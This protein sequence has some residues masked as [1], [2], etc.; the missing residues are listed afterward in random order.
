MG[1][2]DRLQSALAHRGLAVV[3]VSED[4]GGLELVAPFYR[5]HG[6]EAL[7][8]YLDPEGRL[9]RAFGIAGLPTTFLIDSEGRL[10]GELRGAAEWDGPAA[11][12]LVG[13]YLE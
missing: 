1:S 2:L 13:H 11:R 10:V 8:I 4:R 6:L 3:A 12:A 9:R 5:E 7:E